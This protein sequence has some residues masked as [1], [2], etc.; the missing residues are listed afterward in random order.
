MTFVRKQI[1]KKVLVRTQNAGV[2]FGTLTEAESVN[3]G[4]DVELTDSRRIFSW[5]GAF[6]LSELAAIGPDNKNSKISCVVPIH[7]MRA[8]EIIPFTDSAFEILNAIP[9]FIP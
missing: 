7:Y 2:H 4:F 6:T 9:R 8:I 5:S 1:G 3:D